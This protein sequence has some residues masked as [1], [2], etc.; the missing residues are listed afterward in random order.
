MRQ[1][2]NEETSPVEVYFDDL[3]V[4][5]IKSPI[6]QQEDFY[7][8]GLSFNSYSRENTV[9]QNFLY[10]SKE[11]INDLGLDWADYGARMYMPE[12]GRWG[13][14]DPL[15]EHYG[16]FSPYN[17]VLNDPVRLIDPNGMSATDPNDGDKNDKGQVY[18]ADL[19]TWV[20][21]AQYGNWKSMLADQK[22]KKEESDRKQEE[23]EHSGQHGLESGIQMIAGMGAATLK[24]TALLY[25]GSE[26]LSYLFKG[27][28]IAYQLYRFKGLTN[29]AAKLA[30]EGMPNGGGH[31][32]RHLMNEGLISNSGSLA[33]R[34]EQFS[35][36]ATRIM[37]NPIATYQRSLRGVQVIGYEGYQAGKRV[38][39]YVAQEGQYAGKVISSVIIK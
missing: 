13:V 5:Q 29:S 10:N 17:Y 27:G 24:E 7:P 34:V 23:Y 14:V 19:K 16:S 26:L 22:S 28:R 11:Q 9:A 30:I 32:I 25:S 1:L 6:V 38:V 37:R 31:A 4:Q 36:F 21:Q 8:F 2:S 12:I 20:T 39:V 15:S 3:T 33:S 35:E 18:N